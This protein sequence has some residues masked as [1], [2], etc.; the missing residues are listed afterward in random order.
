MMIEIRS[1]DI[2]LSIPI[3]ELVR[4]RVAPVLV[5]FLASVTAVECFLQDTMGP[6]GSL[7]KI[8]RLMVA[9]VGTTPDIVVSG[10]G[11]R[12]RVAVQNACRQ[13]RAALADDSLHTWALESAPAIDS[14]ED[15][16]PQSR[17]RIASPHVGVRAHPWAPLPPVS[18]HPHRPERGER[19]NQQ[20][21]A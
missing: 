5:P 20:K 13:L 16:A 4:R 2:A 9:R 15:F 7:D 14:E 6:A 10:R 19:L 11:N 1:V 21:V 17:V 18:R 12:L 3:R 8:C